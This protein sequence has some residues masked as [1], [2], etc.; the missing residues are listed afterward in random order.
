M[1]GVRIPPGTPDVSINIFMHELGYCEFY[2]TNVC[3]LNCT[4]CNRYNNFA[5]AG[6]DTWANHQ[7]L[8]QQWAKILTSRR[9]GI[10]GGE[11]LLNP[12]FF[13]WLHGIAELW[14]QSEI[15][16]IT[17]GTQMSRWPTLYQEL[18]KYTPRV[19]IEVNW[20]NAEQ[21]NQ[22]YQ[23]LERFLV[24]P[25]IKQD[26]T[27]IDEWQ[28]RYA[29]VRDPSWPDCATPKDFYDLP[30]SIQQECLEVHQLD[31][32]NW[33]END[34][35]KYTRW[36]DANGV[37]VKIRPAWYFHASALKYNSDSGRL[38]LHDS[39]PVKA[40]AVCDFKT[41]HHFI[42]GQLYKCGPV[43]IL[44]S[45]ISQFDVDISQ[46]D[47]H[48]LES[49]EPARP[50]WPVEKLEAFVKDLQDAKPIAQCKFCPESFVFEKFSSS[51]KKIKLVKKSKQ[52]WQRGPMQGIANP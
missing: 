46:A 8:Y 38:C 3:N 28:E 43:G 25:I 49:Y 34:P 50:D 18:R 44:P 23:S 19:K 12:D 15:D 41:C 33:N 26:V 35:G 5:F 21:Q 29:V 30:L 10:L 9:I 11:P 22:L 48:L 32:K 20:H 24:A 31:P 39:D 2:I 1:M 42:S 51:T 14:P 37:I 45:F 17:N 16:I 36:T 27:P 13:N 7:N 4:N 40:M 47:Q 52:R 6:H